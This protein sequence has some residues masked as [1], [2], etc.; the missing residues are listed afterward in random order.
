MRKKLI[1]ISTLIVTVLLISSFTVSAGLFDFFEELVSFVVCTVTLDG[2]TS[3]SE[4]EGVPPPCDGPVCLAS[5]GLCEGRYYRCASVCGSPAECDKAH[6]GEKGLGCEIGQICNDDCECEW[7]DKDLDSFTTTACGENVGNSGWATLGEADVVKGDYTWVSGMTIAAQSLKIEHTVQDVTLQYG[8]GGYSG[9]VTHH[10][11]IY[12]IKVYDEYD[13]KIFERSY[14]NKAL[15]LTESFGTEL[16]VKKVTVNWDDFNRANKARL[17]LFIG[18]SSAKCDCDDYSPYIHPGAEELCDN[19]DND[20]DGETDE[21]GVCEKTIHLCKTDNFEITEEGDGESLSSG[22]CKEDEWCS[23]KTEEEKGS[24]SYDTSQED[25]GV[26]MFYTYVCDHYTCYKF[27]GGSFLVCGLGWSCEVICIPGECN[28]ETKA[29]CNDMGMWQTE[30]WC[31][32]SC[33]ILDSKCANC[34][35]GKCDIDSKKWCK[36]GY[37][38]EENYCNCDVCGKKDSSCTKGCTCE[39]GDCDTKNDKYCEGGF[40]KSDTYC[41]STCC[42]KDYNC[43]EQGICTTCLTGTCDTAN[44]RYCL[45]GIWASENYCDYCECCDADC[46]T[47]GACPHGSCDAHEK[48]YCDNGIWTSL[49]YPVPYCYSHYCGE[50]DDSC[51][52]ACEEGSCDSYANEWCSDGE[53]IEEGFCD[54]CQDSDCEGPC[55]D[56]SCDI[57]ANKWCD[58]ESWIEEGYCGNCQDSDCVGPCEEG[59]CDTYA[60]EWCS[61]EEWIVEDYCNKCQDPDCLL[62]T[63]YEQW[64]C[65]SWSNDCD[66]IYDTQTCLGWIDLNSCG[67]T[68]DKPA[69]TRKCYLD[70]TCTDDDQDGDDY[71]ARACYDVENDIILEEIDCD[72][73]DASQHPGAE[74]VC[75][76]EDDNCDD[77]TDEGCPCVEGDTKTC[78][79]NIGICREGIQ[80]C[81]AGYWSVCGGSGYIGHISEACDDGLDNNCDSYID[82]NC[83]CIEGEIKDCGSDAGICEKG[84]QACYYGSFG[85]V[86][87]DEVASV[88]EVCDNVLDDDCDNFI[89]GDD[90]N[91]QVATPVTKGIEHCKNRK[92]DADEEGVD[93]GGK[94]CESCSEKSNA[95]DYGKI[96]DKC[97]CGKAAYKTGYCCNGK[98]SLVA[99][100]EAP[101]D[102][103]NDGCID[104]KELQIGTDPR[105]EDTDGD[106][107]LD[108][109]S[110]EK[111]PLCNEDSICDSEKEYPE[112]A[113]NCT[114][115]AEKR[116]LLILWI[117][118]LII[119]LALTGIGG[120]LYAKSKGYKLSD[121]IKIKRKK[122]EKPKFQFSFFKKVQKEPLPVKQPIE[123]L[124][125]IKIVSK[126]KTTVQL[127]AFVN[128][129][130]RK[131]YTKLQIRK[132]A[133]EAGWTKEEIDEALKG[134]K[135]RYRLFK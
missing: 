21:G 85:S 13:T 63:C 28:T 30:G 113:Q 39:A 29:W 116:G 4:Q 99:C 89:D 48:Q 110:D 71:P 120:Y 59:A 119:F 16:S 45:K 49:A 132:A 56:G 22:T 87:N 83:N 47:T 35:H 37:W 126:K 102:S 94:D 27:V 53:W 58:D 17:N 123:K 43:Y 19:A 135:S 18:S 133:S 32:S 64:I 111:Q 3:C 98:Y 108:C 41:Y 127:R 14:T 12:S 20:C 114:D 125:P 23:S 52:L 109:D 93:C 80:L 55:E 7:V 24:C 90:S 68:E 84:W 101:K 34:E 40:W 5:Y 96:K 122:E 8:Y 88:T 112:T 25:L 10:T 76:G 69:D 6:P 121:F 33:G 9:P 51:I 79:K 86:C 66:G 15:P 38:T 72:D 67:S 50:Q 129:S 106:G 82:E 92:Q 115:C 70:F 73:S 42:Q 26:N 1:I 2:A 60:N 118:L 128:S 57:Y 130:L 65:D 103:D 131:G 77:S 74:E 134:K 81:E 36:N 44:N 100:K 46:G 91:C 31:Q 78:G 105:S 124:E 107:L 54:N 95:C 11:Y 117:M 104:D 97:V 61:N 75:N 62:P